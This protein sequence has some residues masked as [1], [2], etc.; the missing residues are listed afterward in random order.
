MSPF[1][2]TAFFALGVMVVG[3]LAYFDF[4]RGRKRESTQA[5][6]D[7]VF[8]GLEISQL[9]RVV[10][11]NGS[12]TLEF[13]SLKGVWQI[14]KPWFD[15]GDGAVIGRFF[16][17]V[18]SQDVYPVETEGKVNW[19]EYGFVSP[20]SYFHL[21]AK[22]GEEYRVDVSRE[23]SFDGRYYLKRGDQLFIGSQQWGDLVKTKFEHFRDK[24]LWG[25][26]GK[27]QSLRFIKK[28]K[29][30]L[31][32]GLRQGKWREESQ[33]VE[34]ESRQVKAF[35]RNQMVEAKITHFVEE[36][37][38]KLTTYGLDK[39]FGRWVIG[40]SERDLSVKAAGENFMGEDPANENSVGE[41]KSVVSGGVG[42]SFVEWI[43]TDPSQEAVFMQSSVKPGIYQVSS[44][45][46]RQWVKGPNDFR[47]R[48]APFNFNAN[49]AHKMKVTR[50]SEVIHLIKG[51]KGWVL[52]SSS[53]KKPLP[54][55][56]VV[57]EFMES[58]KS[59][60]V[61]DFMGP[62]EMATSKG[63]VRIE[64]LEGQLLFEIKWSDKFKS[65]RE[66]MTKGDG[67]D[68]REKGVD[69]SFHRVQ[70]NLSKDVLTLDAH[71]IEKLVGVNF[72]NATDSK[73]EEAAHVH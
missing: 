5:I 24:N 14:D 61:K 54:N 32:L 37:K 7:R 1:V 44:I 21:K 4:Q 68:D 3:G 57:G 6:K 28:G 9:D 39:P 52:E 70:T 66:N 65:S 11:S 49:L 45:L 40:W 71:E 48:G 55:S 15:K 63:G 62:G 20:Q 19:P 26:E 46:A 36:D 10:F 67:K 22:G 60:E 56:E 72:F 18:L 38:K 69:L 33:G 27:I 41:K 73:G 30:A 8:S 23:T 12:Q 51:D 64:S 59:L 25:Q 31:K 29:E 47:D 50:K 16:M 2:K 17:D 35:I 13:Q 34:I 53:D 58:L 42:I 43:F